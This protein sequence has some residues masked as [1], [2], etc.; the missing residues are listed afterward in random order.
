MFEK[1]IFSVVATLVPSLA[2]LSRR[3]VPSLAHLSRRL[4]RRAY[5]IEVVEPAS[6][7]RPSSSTFSFNAFSSE[8][9]RQN[10]FIFHK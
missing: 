4:T 1:S 7:R 9:A 3:L 6:V 2:H 8:A 10:L 5:S